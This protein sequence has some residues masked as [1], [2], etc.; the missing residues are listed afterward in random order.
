M[1]KNI[2]CYLNLAVVATNHL[3]KMTCF[4]PKQLLFFLKVGLKKL[5]AGF[6]PLVPRHILLQLLLSCHIFRKAA[7]IIAC[8][9]QEQVVTDVFNNSI[10]A[11]SQLQQHIQILIYV[12][13]P[14]VLFPLQLIGKQIYHSAIVNLYSHISICKQQ[15]RF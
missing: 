10:T 12:K 11:E 15:K 8:L 5:K 7:I 1:R 14:T 3:G 2:G 9:F 13:K 6:S 4:L